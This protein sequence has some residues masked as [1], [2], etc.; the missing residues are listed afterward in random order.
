MRMSKETQEQF[1]E[2]S[3]EIAAL[4]RRHGDNIAGG[5][6]IRFNGKIINRL[7]WLVEEVE[8]QTGLDANKTSD[9]DRFLMIQNRFADLAS[10]HGEHSEGDGL[11]I[12]FTA[13]VIGEAQFL[14]NEINRL[15]QKGKPELVAAGQTTEG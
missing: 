15:S 4:H 8:R 14:V 11:W 12:T 2:I 6:F 13:H 5:K 10:T 3:K 9:P 1:A 7:L